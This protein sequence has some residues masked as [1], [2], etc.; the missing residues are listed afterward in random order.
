MTISNTGTRP[1]RGR[2]TWEIAGT[3]IST[4]RGCSTADSN[5][6]RRACHSTGYLERV[7]DVAVALDSNVAR[8]GKHSLKIQF[9][10]QANVDYHHA[11]QTA[12][13]TPGVYRFQ[14]FVRADGIT[15]DQGLGFRISGE[16]LSVTTDQV[17]R[18]SDWTRLEQTVRVPDRTELL[19]IHVV[20]QK[21]LK[22]DSRIAGTVWI[23]DVSLTRVQ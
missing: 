6:S 23:D 10:G 5:L 9:D 18:T 19:T 7:D 2:L 11:F 17:V 13:V 20:R 12:L 4:R 16:G 22:F 8:S 21:S 3:A 1:A 14:G 15:T